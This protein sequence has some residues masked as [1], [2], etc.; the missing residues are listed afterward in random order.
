MTNGYWKFSAWINELLLPAHCTLA[1]FAI[2]FFIRYETVH[3]ICLIPAAILPISWTWG[4]DIVLEIM[5]ISLCLP[6]RHNSSPQL[7]SPHLTS[8]HL[9]S[10]HLTSPHLTSPH[11]TS[12][13]LTSPHLTSPHLTSPHHSF[14]YIPDAW[15]RGPKLKGEDPSIP[16]PPESSCN[17]GQFREKGRKRGIERIRIYRWMHKGFM[18]LKYKLIKLSHCFSL[19]LIRL[20][21]V[22]T[23]C[24]FN[25]S[26]NFSLSSSRSAL[27]V[28]SF[29]QVNIII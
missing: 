25:Q 6:P 13:H 9:T 19:V 29:I 18:K 16:P 5:L 12:P 14:S 20:T 23:L 2:F 15:T 17:Y 26:D 4:R 22:H 8:P 1:I 7:T 11:L 21:C 24:L 3:A 10:P 27:Q 28:W